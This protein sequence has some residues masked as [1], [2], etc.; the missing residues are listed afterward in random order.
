MLRGFSGITAN[1]VQEF[2]AVVLRVAQAPVG[3]AD[4]DCDEFI[5]IDVSLDETCGLRTQS[6]DGCHR[7]IPD[8][9]T[10]CPSASGNEGIWVFIFFAQ[11]A[12]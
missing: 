2:I 5:F 3:F 10:Y 12:A 6:V 4:M 9:C 1:I 11:E 8:A 7:V